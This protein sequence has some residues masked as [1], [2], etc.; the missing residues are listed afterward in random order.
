MLGASRLERATA[1]E[2]APAARAD[3]FWQPR[4][5]T[6]DGLRLCYRSAGS[7]E[8]VL[9]LHGY[10]G[11]GRYWTAAAP[12]LAARCRVIA[13]D[14]KGFG[15]SAKPR[16]GYSLTEHVMTLRHFLAALGL[17][18]VTLV[19]HS[20]GGVLALRLL[21]DCPEL[22]RRIVLVATPLTG[23]VEQNLTEL[24]HAPA[25]MRLLVY[26]PRLAR[27][28]VGIHSQ[29]V[30]RLG[31][32]TR[33]LPLE[34]IQDA[35][36]FCWASLRET[37]DSC[38]VRENMR[39]RLPLQPLSVPA[40]LLYGDQDDLVAPHHAQDV[41][42][43]FEHSRLIV[44]PGAGHQLPSSHQAAFLAALTAFLAAEG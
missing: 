36:K 40:L 35:V 15:D 1:R 3:A 30:V 21:L 41:A 22:V 31:S 44:I 23:T 28:V 27:W 39:A 37:F 6:V 43:L 13:P 34:S 32:D 19:G 29:A 33:D 18:R 4:Y 11:S 10:R 26:R 38:I 2:L 8:P 12:E 17:P 7:G 25:W 20:L 42:A 24:A 16:T 9:L 5:V 14:L